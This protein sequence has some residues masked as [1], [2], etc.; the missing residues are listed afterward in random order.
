MKTHALLDKI[1]QQFRQTPRT[2]LVTGAAG[3]I[4]SHLV[5]ELLR[6]EQRVIGLD[7]FSTGKEEN[8]SEV[9]RETGSQWS[10][11]KLVRGDIRDPLVCQ[12]AVKHVDIVLHQAALGSVPR[13]IKNPIATNEHNITGTLNLLTA[14]KDAGVRRFVYPSSSSVYG[15]NT[16]LPKVE[17][18]TGKPL[19]P[20]AI[21]K[22]ANELYAKVFGELFG[23]ETIGLRYFNVF[24]P[25]QLL[26]GPYAA[27]IPNWIKAILN[28]EAS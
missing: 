14:A 10:K 19:S 7:N 2:W 8:L 18:R 23:I 20:Y 15:D 5:E 25:R 22:V 6:L 16:D 21:T 27:V 17:N 4:G 3:F 9:E 11:F 12:G 26:G 13:S 24:G 1:S 28:E